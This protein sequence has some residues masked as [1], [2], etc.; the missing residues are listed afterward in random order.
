[1]KKLLPAFL[2]F[3]S[4]TILLGACRRGSHAV[5]SIL[6]LADSL[7]QSHPDSSLQLLEAIPAPQKMGKTDR[8]WYALL[9]T[10][11]KYK[12]YVSL[13]NDS[14]IQVAVDYFEKN[15]D[16][17]RLAKSYFYSG[18]VHREQEDI[19]TAINLYLKSLRT[20]PQGGDSVFLSMIYGHLGDCYGEQCLNSVAIDAHKNA[21]ALCGAAHIDRALYALLKIGDNYLIKDDSDSAFIYYQQAKLLADSLQTSAF[22]PLVYKNIAALY[23]E[24]GKY[25]EANSYISEAMR[26]IEVE[27]SLYSTYFLKGDIM[28]HLNKKDSAL[29]YWNLA[30]YSFDIE[31]KASAFDRLFELNKEQSR[32]REAA[33]CADSFIVYFDSIQASAYRAEIGDLMDNHQ[34]EI[35]KYALL[36]EHQLAK[37]KMIYCFWGLFLVLALIYMW[38]DRCRKNKYIALQKQLNE[39]RAEIMM[40]SESSAPIEEKSAELHDLKEKNLQICISL[41]EATEGYKKLNELKNMK[42]GKRILKIQDYRERIIGDIRESFLDV[43]NNLRENCRSLTNED[44]F[45]CLLSLLHCPK[46]LLLGIMDASS[47]AI[48]ARKHRIKD[49]MD[50][51]L[52]DKVFGSDNQ[53]LM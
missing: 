33:L 43:M 46:D 36:K 39:N 41:F 13:E 5:S 11:A 17:E 40:L 32:W 28:N 53:K 47:D 12:N 24:R 6:L 27:E 44:L 2:F 14:L 15:S 10:Q 18:C 50:T 48:K 20:M 26:D 3:I 37:K 7:M 4:F 19:P 30:K 9:L 38:R 29:Y 42:P 21:Y 1:M 23:N 49:K 52:F 31:T 45:Y 22:K 35:H 51:V 16:R 34:L 25:E 8:A